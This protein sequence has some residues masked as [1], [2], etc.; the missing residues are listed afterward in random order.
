MTKQIEFKVTPYDDVIR[1][2]KLMATPLH[3]GDVILH[4]RV[5][6]DTLFFAIAGKEGI[7]TVPKV[8]KSPQAAESL[9]KKAYPQ[10]NFGRYYCK[11][12]GEYLDFHL[13]VFMPDGQGY[14]TEDRY[15]SVFSDPKELDWSDSIQQSTLPKVSDTKGAITEWTEAEFDL[16]MDSVFDEVIDELDDPYFSP[17]GTDDKEL[18]FTSGSQEELEHITQVIC[19]TEISLF[20]QPIKWGENLTIRYEAAGDFSDGGF[21]SEYSYL[22]EGVPLSERIVTLLGLAYEY[23]SF[24][25]H[26]WVYNDGAYDRQS[27]YD[28]SPITIEVEV[29]KPSAHEIM[30]APAQLEEW[31]QDKVPANELQSLLGSAP[32][33]EVITAA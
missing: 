9:L 19:A 31:L 18:S 3:L 16:F 4:Y 7:Y 24:T 14:Y 20:S 25:G 33:A 23:N 32:E 10:G 30:A 28:K 13:F 1:N 27:G 26:S 5:V 22:P 29:P 21:D 11:E 2:T 6:E 12:Y 8:V 17:D 15:S